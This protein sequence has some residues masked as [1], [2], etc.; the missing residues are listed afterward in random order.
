VSVRPILPAPQPAMAW[1]TAAARCAVAIAVA[2]CTQPLAASEAPPPEL[3]VAVAGISTVS[4]EREF[5]GEVHA[6]QRAEIRAR[7]KGVV[8]SVAVDEGQDVTPGQ[9]LFTVAARELDQELRRARAAVAVAGAELHAAD[10]EFSNTRSL[11]G[12][13]VVAPAE[14]AQLR[15]RVAALSARRAEAKAVEAG[16]AVQRAY[17]EVRSP[18]AGTIHRIER[19]VGSLVQEGDLLTTVADAREVLVYFR[20]AEA[21]YLDQQAAGGARARTVWLRLA[22][23]ADYPLAGATDAVGGEFDRGTGTIALR[24]RF[25]N[26]D[27]LLKHGA[28]GKVIVKTDIPRAVLVPQR[29]TLEVQDH[30]YL[31]VVGADGVARMRR[32]V[33]RARHG[34][35][36]IVDSGLK[37]GERYVAE[38]VQF[39]RDGGRI[40]VRSG[41]AAGSP[42]PR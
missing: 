9:L 39:V 1:A 3:P 41:A 19:K 12:N 28:T 30:V 34:D 21:E 40:A 11:L 15:A 7:V 22:N 37:S 6:V 4:V 33:P 13:G 42:A 27:G 14:A 8:E 20:V 17:T 32:I 38:G 10:Q 23:G 31:Y 16:A 35:A 25:V 5:V 24:A 26:V 2:A 29:A 36:F 18:F